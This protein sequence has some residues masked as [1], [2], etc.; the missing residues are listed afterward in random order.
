MNAPIQRFEQSRIQRRAC[1][2]NQ[3]VI[4]QV[5]EVTNRIDTDCLKP[6]AS[7]Q[8]GVALQPLPLLGLVTYHYA[9]GILP[10]REIERELWINAAFREV[11]GLEFPRWQAIRRFRRLNRAVIHECL[12]ETLRQ[13]SPAAVHSRVSVLGQTDF[14]G[15]AETRIENAALLDSQE[16]ET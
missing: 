10:S 6:V 7:T 14:S 2:A 3:F 11:C 12:A 8:A 5:L 9:V 15:E 16:D 4:R 1:A 13:A